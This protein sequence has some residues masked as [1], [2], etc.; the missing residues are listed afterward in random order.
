MENAPNPLCILT[1]TTPTGTK[2]T[3]QTP[4]VYIG[5]PNLSTYLG[6]FADSTYVICVLGPGVLVRGLWRAQLS[7]QPTPESLRILSPVG[8]FTIP[9]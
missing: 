5:T 2:F 8:V 4:Q 7:F 1:F 3:A 9:S 6:V